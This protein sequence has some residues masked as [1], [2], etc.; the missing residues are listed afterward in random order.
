MVQRLDHHRETASQTAGPYV[1]IGLT[2]NFIGLK[3]VYAADLGAQMVNDQTRGER[4]TITG[5][6]FDGGGAPVRDAVIEIWQADASGLYNSPS[7][8]R[9]KADPEFAGWGRQPTDISEGTYV[10]NTIKPGMVPHPDGRIQAPHISF[11]IIARGI[12]LGLN[13]RMYFADETE[14]N[15]KDPLLSRIDPQERVATLLAQRSGDTY[16]FDI[17]LQGPGETVFFDI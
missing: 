5:R 14:A 13:T 4:I 9:G 15:A 17:R 10:F 6:V 2:P 11:F 7:E 12:N 16:A 3:G 8:T 1:H